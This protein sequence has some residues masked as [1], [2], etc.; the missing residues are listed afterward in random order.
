MRETKTTGLLKV[1]NESNLE[2]ATKEGWELVERYQERSGWHNV[3]G[4]SGGRT[5]TKFLMQL[6]EGNSLARANEEIQQLQEKVKF[7]EESDKSWGQANQDLKNQLSVA[8]RKVDQL[9]GEKE[10]YQE[11]IDAHSRM[12][13]DLWKIQDAIGML[14]MAEI[15][16]EDK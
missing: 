11:A 13:S 6:N 14:R 1:V 3:S 16:N 2:T 5:N 8:A 4:E 7:L 12:E 9:T 10:R 15:L